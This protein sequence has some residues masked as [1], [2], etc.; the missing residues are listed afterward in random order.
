MA[1]VVQGVD[2]VQA[3]RNGSQVLLQTP[4]HAVQ[5]LITEIAA[6]TIVDPDWYVRFCPKSV[7]AQDRLSVVAKVLFP[8]IPRRPREP[9]IEYY[10]RCERLLKRALKI[11][12]FHSAWG[13]TYFQRLLSL[14]NSENQ[15]ERAIRI[16]SEWEVRGETAIVMHTSSPAIDRLRKRGSPCLQYIEILWGGDGVLDLVAV[17][18][19]HD[20]LN[21]ALGNFIGLGRLLNFIAFEGGKRSGRVICHSVHAYVDRIAMFRALLA[22]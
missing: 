9:R 16:L 15:I 21:K 3:W 13:G 17:Y 19:N 4:Q 22:K 2:A 10:A 1:I 12:N 11:G 5:N 14:D 8:D 6:P 18:R 20:F 7:G